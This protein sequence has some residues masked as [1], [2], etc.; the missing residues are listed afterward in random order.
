[1][2]HDSDESELRDARVDDP[3]HSAVERQSDDDTKR[4]PYDLDER[5]H[6][7]GDYVTNTTGITTGPSTTTGTGTG[8]PSITNHSPRSGS[9]LHVKP[10]HHDGASCH[11]VHGRCDINVN[12]HNHNHHDD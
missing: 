2:L 6:T 12:D 5:E 11:Y 8:T 7:K 3:S 10:H 4:L 1:M 9:F